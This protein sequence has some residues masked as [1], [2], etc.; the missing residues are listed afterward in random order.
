VSHLENIGFPA[1]TVARALAAIGFG[2]GLGKVVFGWLCDMIQPKHSCA[3]G[4]LLQFTALLLLLQ[5][6][7]GSPM[8]L[9]WAYALVM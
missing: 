2:S 4:H 6:R 9:F 3:V 7:A 8:A 1:T 5:V